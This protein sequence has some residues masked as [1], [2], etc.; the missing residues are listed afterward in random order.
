M[1]TCRYSVLVVFLG[2]EGIGRA[3]AP[4]GPC[5]ERSSAPF[6]SGGSREWSVPENLGATVNSTFNEVLAQLSPNGLSL[7][8]TSDRPAPQGAP[9]TTDLWVSQR[10]TLDGDWGPPINLGA[11]VNTSGNERSPFVTPD[12][13][14]L[15]FASTREGGEGSFD[16]WVSFRHDTENDLG[17]RP[18]VP[19]GAAINGPTQDFA[20]R[21]LERGDTGRPNLYFGSRRPTVTSDSDI[22]VSELLPDGS[23]GPGEM[24]EELSTPDDDQGLTLRPDGLELF[25]NSNRPGSGLVD[26]WTSTRESIFAPWSPPVNLGTRINTQYADLFPALSADGTTLVFTSNRPD[27][28]HRV[29][30]DDLYVT[31]RKKSSGMPG[32]W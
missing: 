4:A 18:A 26:I 30:G 27:D 31:T 9:G 11:N 10:A 32:C 12:G 2:L 16:L 24:V 7:Y 15:Y 13:H 21:F 17:W 25:F 14:F 5:P 20:P 1:R 6:P 19:L 23:F 3:Q 29:G 28:P 8:F 22:Y